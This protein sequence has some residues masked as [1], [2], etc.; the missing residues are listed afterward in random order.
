MEQRDPALKPVPDRERV[1]LAA[2]STCCKVT[3]AA[4]LV[5]GFAL[6]SLGI[7]MARGS[8]QGLSFEHTAELRGI[9]YDR[10]LQRRNSDY[11]QTLTPALERLFLTS[12]RGS[13]LEGSC[14]GCAILEYR[15][16]NSSV[17]VRFRLR[18]SPPAA[19]S[20]SPSVEEEALRHGLAAA[21]RE[22][23]IPLASY[24]TI[25]SASLTGPSRPAPYGLELKSGRCPGNV[26]VCHNSQCVWKE[27]PECDGQADC[28]DGSDEADCA[29]GSRPAMQ[30]AHRIV[31]G[32][33][34]SRGE[35]PWQ[36]SL[37]ENNEH[38]CGAT[39]LTEKWLVS[40]A[41]CF[42]EF[43]DP[44]VWAAYMGTVSLSGA[45][46][47]TVKAGVGRIIPHPSYNTDTADFDVAVLELDRPVPF[48]KYIQPACLP[49]PGHRFPA[50]RKCLI[51]GWGYLRED[52]LVKPETL[53]KAP[54][55][56]L[57]QGLCASLYS[58][59]LTDRM[60]CAGYL[61]G[62]IDSCQ[63]DSG[64]PLVCE[65]PSGKFFLAGI[66]SWGIGCAEAKRPGVYARVTQ[67][68]DWILAAISTFPTPA[69]LTL[70][71]TLPRPSSGAAPVEGTSS[72]TT[73]RLSVGSTTRP[74]PATSTLA[75]ASRPQGCGGRPGL[76]K[77]S[78]IVGGAEASR[79]EV[80]WQASLKEGARHFCG[81]TVV[82][83]RWL[84]SAAHCFNQTRLDYLRADLG[85]TSLSGA[86]GSALSVSIKQVVQH[87]SYN[88]L[89]LDFDVAVLELASPLRFS[90]YIQPVCL[91]L[92]VQKFP[93][94]KKCMISGWG[95]VREGNISKPASLQKASV[96]IIDQKTCN[97]LY[98]FSLTERMICAGFLEGRVDSCQGDSGGP[99][100]CEESPGLFYLAGVVSWG[101]GCA[102]AK[103]PGVYARVT[104]L[105]DWIL[106]TISPKS[107]LSSGAGTSPSLAT[108]RP[109]TASSA[110][111]P[112]SPS[113]QPGTSPARQTT[114]LPPTTARKTSAAPRP[115]Q[116]PD[117]GLTPAVAFSKIVGGSGAARG[118]WPWQVS[119]R[120]RRKEHKCGAVLIA[121]KW[122]LSAAHCFDVYSDPKMWVA[123]LGTPF[124]SGMDGRA[125][126]IF[127]IHKHPFYN[128]YTLD[129]DV[130]LLE[131]ATAVRL[132]STI[133]PICLPD[134][135]HVFREGARCVIT[136]WGATKEGGLMSKHL[137]KAA[138]S[139]MGEQACRKFYPI[140]ISSRMVCAG[141]PQ[142]TIDSCS[143]DAG[144]PLACREASGR[145]FLAGITSWGYGC[146]RP[147]FPGVYTKV[148][149]VRGWI[150]QSLK[151]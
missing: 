43:Q 51:S 58:H 29:C 134:N 147:F 125:E 83:E 23:G 39:I 26:F 104:Q 141:F 101:I 107:Q 138:V 6:L 137:Q 96:G 73:G 99:L 90:K 50:G 61:E 76:S 35:F 78:K 89:L 102:Q 133:R 53:Q 4:V 119:L 20:L 131:L 67:L 9:A 121:E 132:T 17:L 32:T 146:A 57:E 128:V 8:A 12:F 33:E 88:P 127:H 41:H 34:A 115:S 84:L 5:G 27:N 93:V 72:R 37:R 149:A 42:N 71:T 111:A 148:T 129:Y 120:L 10:S 52:F 56:L 86:D 136:G 117:C 63:G 30:V 49:G 48:N 100:A 22:Q 118:E 85:T 94:G 36:V 113:R 24:G 3:I 139:V 54:V 103:R 21:L 109:P 55:E 140:Q 81:A 60:L 105:Q 74:A 144:G 2:R 47:S 46:S 79:G 40:A 110:P 95:S 106:A 122:L 92:A 7:L 13:P 14:L 59:T 80:P 114:P 91:P 151:L 16:G 15:N 116:L 44:A 150:G 135:S 143:G 126:K 124:L 69:A 18:F 31:G 123:V 75:A 97:V 19:W 87:P 64:G 25:A 11:S 45:D 65:E 62:K 1:R 82:G 68:R 70:P 98:N 38:F 112:P 142:G 130:A 77:P 108:A 145:W 66:V 28:A